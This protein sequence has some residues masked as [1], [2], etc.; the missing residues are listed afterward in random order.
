MAEIKKIDNLDIIP[1]KNVKENSVNYNSRFDYS[2]INN[3]VAK[4]NKGDDAP[5]EYTS[6]NP[7]TTIHI[8]NYGGGIYDRN[9]IQTLQFG[10]RQESLA[11]NYSVLVNDEVVR[12]II[13]EY[14]PD[15][16]FT[17]DGYEQI[18]WLFSL[19]GSVGCG[20]V[21]AIN[22][23]MAHSYAFSDDYFKEHFGY[24]RNKLSEDSNGKSYIDYNYEY[25]FL[26]FFLFYARYYKGFD[27]IEEAIGNARE[28]GRGIDDALAS[29]SKERTGMEGTYER[30]V[31]DVFRSFL[32]Y[33]DM[34]V[35][36][37]GTIPSD[38]KYFGINESNSY[39][40]LELNY[41]ILCDII[42]NKHNSLVI[43]GENFPLYLPYDENGNGKLDD[44]AWY[45]RNCDGV[46]DENEGYYES[47]GPHAMT[48]VGTTS[49]PSK[50]VVSSWGKEFVMDINDVCNFAVYTYDAGF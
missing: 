9:A 34:F 8:P 12:N 10:G 27:T 47:V 29:D 44:V 39:Y 21:A 13:A 18:G 2:K 5:I 17:K 40:D 3:Y 4:A 33:K 32:L 23:F 16:D 20:Y 15:V 41:D 6:P 46:H 28:L 43:K 7:N 24:S 50:I 25:L 45:D 19:M 22:T 42:N 38:S 35:D 14:Y 37:S 11:D 26:D 48:V 31:A 49:D 1:S 30:V 36:V